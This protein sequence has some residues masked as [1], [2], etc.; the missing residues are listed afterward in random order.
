MMHTTRCQC[1]VD[2]DGD[3]NRIQCDKV[4]GHDG[5]CDTV[6]GV[7]WEIDANGD[8]VLAPE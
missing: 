8:E 1:A 7:E 4:A 6:R 5:G 2:I 3:G